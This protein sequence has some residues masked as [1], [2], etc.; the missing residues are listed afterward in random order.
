V[1]GGTWSGRNRTSRVARFGVV[2]GRGNNNK[3][4]N[5]DKII[6][7]AAYGRND[8]LGRFHMSRAPISLLI[9]TIQPLLP[10]HHRQHDLYTPISKT[11]PTKTK[12]PRTSSQ[13]PSHPTGCVHVGIASTSSSPSAP[14]GAG[15]IATLRRLS[16][17]LVLPPLL[18]PL[19]ALLSLDDDE[20]GGGFAVVVLA[21][22]DIDGDGVDVDVDVDAAGVEGDPF[23]PGLSARRFDVDPDEDAAACAAPPDRGCDAPEDD[24]D[25]AAGCCCCCCDC[26]D[27]CDGLLGFEG[28]AI[29]PPNDGGGS[30]PARTG[31]ADG[32]GVCVRG[33]SEPCLAVGILD[34]GPARVAAVERTLPPAAGAPALCV[35]VAL[36]AYCI[37]GDPP[38]GVTLRIC[39][40][41]DGVDAEG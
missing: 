12:T 20:V 27:P 1:A 10:R 17:L 35:G 34:G 9:M 11:T 7:K 2:S 30:L 29:A 25:D 23:A 13:F 16:L 8:A 28:P 5:R 31:T 38:V 14:C 24:D 40:C 19:R 41:S 36:R 37:C 21:F 26:V 6:T 4:W 32:V 22:F 39:T 15:Y 18:S 33:G 3:K